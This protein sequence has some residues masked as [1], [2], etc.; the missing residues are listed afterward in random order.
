MAI[1][2]HWQR[3]CQSKVK[4]EKEALQ[5]LC[6]RDKQMAKLIAHV[7]ELAVSLRRDY[8]HS[9]VRAIIGQQISVKAAGA[10]RERVW[11]IVPE[12]TPA[13]LCSV[14]PEDLKAAGVSI[15]KVRYL[16]GLAAQIASG[17]L[18]L[19]DFDSM[20]DEE[21][22]VRLTQVKGIGR[23][24]AE[25]FLIFS[26]GRQDVLAYDD[27]GIQRGMKWLY[28]LPA[29]PSKEKMMVYGE[30]WKPFRSVASFYLWE[31]INSGLINQDPRDVL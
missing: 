12:L 8:F 5:V 11:Q 28:Q 1:Q 13:S 2:L 24:T 18:S 27:I 10:I 26:L 4:I 15:T 29:H 9:L 16:Q 23:W 31:V 21:V 6:K 30:K 14:R 3:G 22:I 20:P 19:D 25:V 7:G 17:E